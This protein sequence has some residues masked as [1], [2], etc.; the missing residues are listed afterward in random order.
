MTPVL[1]GLDRLVRL[2]RR[3][4]HLFA[5]APAGTEDDGRLSEV[6]EFGGNPGGLRMLAH[7]PA[8]LPAGAPLVVAL[9]GCTQS[10][11]DYDRGCGWSAMAD[12]LGFA[13]LLPEQRSENNPRRCFN[14]FDPEDTRRDAGE[15]ASIR[16]MVAHMLRQH[17]LDPRRVFITG[18]SAGG[19]MTSAMLACYPEV[20]AAGA[21]LAGLPYGAAASVPQAFDAMFHPKSLPAEERAASVRAA[22][23][24]AGPWPR[25]SVWQGAADRTV[26]PGNADEILKQWLALHGQA[27]ERP[28]GSATAGGV[29]HRLWLAA[30]GRRLVESY[31]IESL[32]HG[33]PLHPPAGAE[34]AAGR[35]GEAGPYML[36]VGLSSTHAILDFWGLAPAPQR[37][38]VVSAAG[39]TRE[40]TERPSLAARLLRRARR[41][42]GLRG[43]D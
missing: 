41:L 21:I 43:D 18:L 30:D 27:L 24:H 6:A 38:F 9:H 34:E 35:V 39:E 31:A 29:T 7:V 17:R 23:G 20:F 19:G 13:V 8:T 36:D 3:W 33:V 40:V 1:H 5:G 16:E 11:A 4:D 12:R 2:R 37:A 42:A 25:V 32:A 15:A 14:W 28:A 26:A 10:A 22:S